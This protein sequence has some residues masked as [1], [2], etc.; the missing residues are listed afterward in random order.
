MLKISR[1]GVESFIKCK[2]CFVLQYKHKVRPPG[3]PFTLNI[4]IDNL[5][6]NEFDYYRELEEPHPILIEHG[7]DAIPFKHSDLDTWR[8]NFKGIRYINEEDG[9]NFGG[10]IDDVWVKPSGELIVSDAKATSVNEFKWEDRSQYEYAKGYERQI[11]MYQWLFRRNGFDV[12]DEGYLIYYNGL[13]NEPMFDQKLEFELH[14]IK[15]D[16]DDSWVEQTIL[17]AV[18][19]LSSDVFPE[20]SSNCDNCNYLRAR[21]NATKQ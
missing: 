21:W 17:E 14:L 16:C 13:K 10:A 3:L 1:S 2:R 12:A 5:C 19:L 20:A 9:Y 8:N 11:E 6:K 15:L 7:I 4:A 18:N